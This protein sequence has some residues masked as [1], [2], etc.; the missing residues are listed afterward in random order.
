MVRILERRMLR[1]VMAFDLSD[2]FPALRGHFDELPPGGQPRFI[3]QQRP[4]GPITMRLLRRTAPDPIAYTPPLEMVIE[5]TSAGAAL[6]FGRHRLPGETEP[7]RVHL[8]DGRYTV[9]IASPFYRTQER[10]VVVN[11]DDPPPPETVVL[12]PS[13]GYPFAEVAPLRIDGTDPAD[14]AARPPGNG[15]TLLRG[16]LAA[17]DGTPLS[18]AIIAT[19]D[20]ADAAPYETDES[21]QWVL[22]F[23][24][25]RPSG[26]RALTISR[27]NALDE[28]V[29]GVC[30]V[31]GRVTSLTQTALRG[32]VRAAGVPVTGAVITLNSRPEAVPSGI[33][34]SWTHV[35]A[36]SQPEGPVTVTAQLPSGEQAEQQIHVRPRATVVVPAFRFG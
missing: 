23:R 14:C 11:G 7:R 2:G 22:V 6:F 32:S 3:A 35:F 12:L 15:P 29:A 9:R 13:W 21:G 30:V 1:A 27:P 10:E 33:D 5:R 26:A 24:D 34:G 17:V 36:F 4:L 31:R 18:G 19:A 16:T 20:A 25:T 8:P 28:T